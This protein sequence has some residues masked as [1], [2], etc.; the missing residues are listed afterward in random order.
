MPLNEAYHHSNLTPTQQR[1]AMEAIYGGNV[2]PAADQTDLSFE[3]VERLRRILDRYDKAQPTRKEFDLAK[4]PVPPYQF[5]AFPFLMYNHS[6]GKTQAAKSELEK[7]ALIAEG[8][9]VE[10]F[11]AEAPAPPQL[12]A[13]ETAEAARVDTLLKMPPEEF[14]AMVSGRKKK[15]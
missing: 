7:T 1:E 15:T 13:Q 5:K 14:E 2:T 9:S 10:P 11:P 12:T 6:T 4:P 8:W 3:E